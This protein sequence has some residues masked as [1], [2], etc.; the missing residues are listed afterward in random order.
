MPIYLSIFAPCPK[1]RWLHEQNQPI[2]SYPQHHHH[3]SRGL[4][5][6]GHEEEQENE[7]H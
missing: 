1:G 4:A 5:E 2:Y 3:Q 7:Q 6:W